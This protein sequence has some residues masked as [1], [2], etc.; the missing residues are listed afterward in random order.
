M[1]STALLIV[2]GLLI[3]GVCISGLRSSRQ[4]RMDRTTSAPDDAARERAAAM[5]QR[6]EALPELTREIEKGRGW[7]PGGA[8]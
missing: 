8:C 1:S 5:R 3:A 6:A 4:Q 7:A 2:A